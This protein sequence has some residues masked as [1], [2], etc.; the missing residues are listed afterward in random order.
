MEGNRP[1]PGRQVRPRSRRT[2]NSVKNHFYSTLRRSL[3]RINKFL[4]SKNSTSQMRDIKPSVLSLILDFSMEN[5][6]EDT[7]TSNLQQAYRGNHAQH[8][9][10]PSLI[11]EFSNF[12]PVKENIMNRSEIMTTE[13]RARF[14]LII[15]K[16][17]EFKYC[18]SRLSDQYGT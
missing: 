15:N 8:L 9:D 7:N 14:E 12:K 16:I 5:D 18:A 11:F 10:L 3:R 13:E 1:Q 6:P 2:D 4:G 17:L